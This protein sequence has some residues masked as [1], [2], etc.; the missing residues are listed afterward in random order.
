MVLPCYPKSHTNLTRDG[1]PVSC[2]L[3][4]KS[5]H[6]WHARA[7]R[8]DR[9]GRPRKQQQEGRAQPRSRRTHAWL[10]GSASWGC[11]WSLLLGCWESSFHSLVLNRHVRWGGA[12]SATKTLPFNPP[13]SI[14]FFFLQ[15]I[16]KFCPPFFFYTNDDFFLSHWWLLLFFTNIY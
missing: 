5:F 14:F 12:L 11:G 6:H 16:G 8:S 13:S 9:T 10:L 1:A 3:G 7:V 2:D 15:K 4:V